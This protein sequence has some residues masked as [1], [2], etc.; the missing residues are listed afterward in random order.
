MALFCGYS[1]RILGVFSADLCERRAC[2]NMKL[3]LSLYACTYAYTCTYTHL[4]DFSSNFHRFFDDWFIDFSWIFHWFVIDVLTCWDYSA[5]ILEVF[6][7]FVV[8]SWDC[9]GS[10]LFVFQEYSRICKFTRTRTHVYICTYTDACISIYYLR[11]YYCRLQD[12]W[13]RVMFSI[14]FLALSHVVARQRIC[15]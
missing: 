13:C 12:A 4:H 11:G 9:F 7:K 10:I 15:S 14:L 1:G 6:W 5:N 3:C 2:W 8:I